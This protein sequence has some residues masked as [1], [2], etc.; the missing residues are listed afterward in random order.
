MGVHCTYGEPDEIELTAMGV[1]L[2]GS[3]CRTSP[4][5]ISKLRVTEYVLSLE[6]LLGEAPASERAFLWSH[7][8]M[9]R[10][11]AEVSGA[12]DTRFAN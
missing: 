10:R 12:A 7:A 8:A 5:G 2:N 9:V 6:W 1:E 3:R 4:G 11:V